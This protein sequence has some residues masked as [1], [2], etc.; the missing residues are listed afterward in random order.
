MTGRTVNA[1]QN[2]CRRR[3]RYKGCEVVRD[4]A[5]LRANAGRRKTSMG[6]GEITMSELYEA[7]CW[8]YKDPNMLTIMKDIS[9]A[10]VDILSPII[11]EF[12]ERRQKAFEAKRTDEA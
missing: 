6:S 1:V 8:C 5:I 11:K 3:D 10:S 4:P 7:Y 12:E 9:C 2:S